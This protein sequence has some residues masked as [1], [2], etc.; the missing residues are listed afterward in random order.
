MAVDLAEDGCQHDRT[1]C[2]NLRRT[3]AGVNRRV[4]AIERQPSLI[5]A[6]DPCPSRSYSRRSNCPLLEHA[7]RNGGNVR[8]GR[9]AKPEGVS[10]AHLL[11]LGAKGK[12]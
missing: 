12:A 9:T 11:R 3:A 10:G 7:R 6:Q 5:A 2:L 1:R 8:D 4:S